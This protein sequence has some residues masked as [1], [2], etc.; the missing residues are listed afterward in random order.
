M[1]ARANC[2]NI[3]PPTT[4]DNTVALHS[5]HNVNI[6]YS[7]R[8]LS[9][10]TYD[11][12]I[13][14]QELNRGDVRRYSGDQTPI[15]RS[16]AQSPPEAVLPISSSS[17][18]SIHLNVSPLPTYDDA[19]VPHSSHNVHIDYSHRRLSLPTYDDAVAQEL[20]TCLAPDQRLC[21]TPEPSM[22]APTSEDARAAAQ[23]NVRQFQ[24]AGDSNQRLCSTPPPVYDDALR[25]HRT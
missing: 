9:L 5:S 1:T 17:A 20:L 13:E 7:H 16:S 3:S 8:R 22:L 10:P 11:D 14:Q 23:A 12:A 6:D 24:S 4:Y 19:V 18:S 25:Q 2:S 15:R 21:L